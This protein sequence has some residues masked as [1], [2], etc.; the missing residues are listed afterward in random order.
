MATNGVS[1]ITASAAGFSQPIVLDR[2]LFQFGVGLLVTIPATVTAVLYSVQVCGDNPNVGNGG[3]TNWNDHDIMKQ[4][5]ASAN[6]NLA[7]PVT[8]L[9]LNVISYVGSGTITFN[10]VMIQKA[11][12]S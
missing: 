12:G 7:F 5:T 6:G 1:T 3:L 11:G 9:R 10:I 8:G 2:G 4:L